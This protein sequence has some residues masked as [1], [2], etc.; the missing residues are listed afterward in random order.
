MKVS[1]HWLSEHLDLDG[2]AVEEMSDLL[3]FAGI[4]VE[5]IEERG[6]RQDS[7]VV[8]RIDSSVPHPG[9]DRLS[10]CQVNDGS[11][12]PRQ[13]VCGARNYAVGDKVPLAL[14]GTVFQTAKGEMKIKKGKL[15]GEV[16]DGMLCSATELG[17]ATESEGLLILAGDASPGTPVQELFASDVIFTIEVT[18]NRPDLLSHLGTARDLAAIAGRTLKSE[19][20]YCAEAGSIASGGDAISVAAGATDSCPFYVARRFTKVQVTESPGWLQ[21]RL[22]SVGIRPINSVVDITNFVLMEMGQPLHA[23]DAAKVKDGIVVRSG[24]AEEKILA[25]DGEE[26]QLTP[27]DVVIA[28]GK[29][30]PLA[31]GGVMGGEASGVTGATADVILESAWFVPTRIRSTSRRLVL[32]SDSSYR[33]ERG[34]DPSQVEGASHLAARMLVEICGA[35]EVGA[36]SVGGSLPASS[37]PS[38]WLDPKDVRSL[39]GAP[40]DTLTD[41]QIDGYLSRLG[42][43]KDSGSNWSIPS[44]RGDLQRPVDLIE[45]VA[46]LHGLDPIPARN[47]ASFSESSDADRL[48][49]FTL[50]LRNRLAALGCYEAMT[51]KL[52][53][54][55]MLADALGSGLDD[56]QGVPLK[57][58]MNDEQTL[59]RPSVVPGLLATVKRNHAMGARAFRFFEAGT[60]FAPGCEHQ[61]L[62]LVIGGEETPS[63]WTKARPESADFFAMTGVLEA[64]LPSR[65]IVLAPAEKEGFPLVATLLVDGTALGRVAQIAPGRARKELGLETPVL[66]AELD[67]E[68]LHAL[69]AGPPK[70]SELPRY[71]SVTR[72]VSLEVP[73]DLR[74]SELADFFEA[75]ARDSEPLLVSTGLFDLFTDPTG[76]KLAADRRSLA[77]TLTYRHGER[78]LET[79]EVDEAHARVLASLKAAHPVTIR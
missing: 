70:F 9:A 34:V 60:V 12:T 53:S 79:A 19:P 51:L 3:T 72:D 69:D 41:D 39:L 25:L 15:R 6:V 29:G 78:T 62:G 57:N 55:D 65:S 16:S 22:L 46:R 48:H 31:I 20:D 44:Y 49:D 37:V 73:A 43:Q 56:S 74:A 26:Y 67:L 76:E 54:A 4:E 10:V 42:L 63:A 71:P 64:M 58:P 5:E 14:P 45:E 68:A 75:Q 52:I 21:Q 33:F 66:V 30:T 77:Y 8:A 38:V 17:L 23:F 18:P 28:D 61:S 35:E 13:I 2:I 24:R 47:R 50:R 1:L 32:S 27:T 40:E 59:L 36:A 7:I 11:G